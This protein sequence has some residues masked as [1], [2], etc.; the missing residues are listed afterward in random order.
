MQDFAAQ[1]PSFWVVGFPIY[2]VALW[3]GVSFLISLAGGWWGLSKKYRT[4]RAFPAH[5]KSFQ[6]GQMR[7]GTGY[8]GVLTLGS[9]A[10]GV[11]LGVL[12][13][14]RVAHPPLFIPWS[15]VEVEESTRYF[16]FRVQR[17]RLGPNRILLMLR[18]P[19]AQF[20]LAERP[21]SAPQTSAMRWGI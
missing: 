10:E 4:E 17:L 19:L 15:D 3:L 1:H 9:D 16:F 20:L 7:G 18:E 21:A 5:K 2:F 13:L 11:Y 8:N 6:R 14:F 12:F